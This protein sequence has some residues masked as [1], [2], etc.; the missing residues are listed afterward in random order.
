MAKFETT[1]ISKI[2]VERLFGRYDYELDLTSE[3]AGEASRVAIL[4]GDNGTGKTTILKL[5]FHLL[6]PE[7]ARGHKTFIARVPFRQ[8]LVEV[9]NGARISILREEPE[10][11]GS[12]IASLSLSKQE[13]VV[14]SFEA[15]DEDSFPPDSLTDDMTAFMNAVQDL[16]VTVYLLSDNRTLENDDILDDIS[17]HYLSEALN[18]FEEHT[19][20]VTGRERRNLRPDPR[21]VGLRE[22]L[23]RVTRW[24]QTGMIEQSNQ[25]E[26]DAQ[27]IYANVVDTINRGATI[28]EPY[29]EMKNRLMEELKTLEKRSNPFSELGLIPKVQ[30]QP[31]LSGLEGSDE[32]SLPFVAQVV[33]SFLDGQDARLNAL[34]R[35][36]RLLHRFVNLINGFL[37]DKKLQ[38]NVTRG[39][40]IISDTEVV[41]SPQNLSSGEKQLLLLFSNVLTASSLGSLFIIDE[42]ELSLNI[43]WQRHLIDALLE[44]T[45]DNN[46][47]FLLASHSFEL[48]AKH[49]ERVVELNPHV[50]DR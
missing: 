42:P 32:Q 1:Q 11:T 27:Q 40:N 33:R 30:F 23:G 6:S 4:Y 19:L 36:N 26:S 29:P 37:I 16:G 48:L 38:A 41:L 15:D 5:L 2:T 13:P 43:K 49:R 12:F 46:C 21:D 25:G 17:P 8:M 7:K 28:V 35:L 3:D 39:V 50:K 10:L 20:T 24:F 47:Q 45:Q 44:L 9:S 34:D 22:S 31:L 18:T 14:A